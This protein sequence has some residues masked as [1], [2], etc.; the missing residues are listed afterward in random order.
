MGEVP[1]GSHY[2]LRGRYDLAICNPVHKKR[3]KQ[4]QILNAGH[5]NANK[6]LRLRRS[7]LSWLPLNPK[8]QSSLQTL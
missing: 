3:C 4:M 8:L 5:V 1:H 7:F 2:A 6:K